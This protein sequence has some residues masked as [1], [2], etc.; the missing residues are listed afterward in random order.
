M[1][2]L[3]PPIP[4]HATHDELLVARLA[5][6]DTLD[7]Q[8]QATASA[9]VAG[10]PDCA[11]MASDIVAIS[12]AVAS[13]AV[14]P[15]RRDY[16]ISDEQAARLRG[17]AVERFFRRFTLTSGGGALK[18][19][20][21]GALSIGLVLV[22]VGS[23]IPRPVE[24]AAAPRVVLSEVAA[25]PSVKVNGIEENDTAG[26]EPPVADQQLEDTAGD[27][28]EMMMT[29]EAAP[30]GEPQGSPGPASAPNLAADAAPEGAAQAR[31]R[32]TVAPSP[33]TFAA[34]EPAGDGVAD[35]RADALADALT[36]EGRDASAAASVV[37]DGGL[38]VG[39]V[40]VA[41]GVALV[42]VGIVLGLL[43]VLA[44]RHPDPLR[45]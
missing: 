17:S 30:A 23:V 28:A 33:A 43:L 4:A 34:G 6:G 27:A 26:G 42:A 45:P 24:P 14:P 16:R 10:C 9:L 15:R 29:L 31:E 7:P 39:L 41:V 2:H 25:S 3:R 22:F 44:R 36:D 19:L 32:R 21:S 18:P 12:H 20:A 1:S 13:E 11:R 35:P 40:L 38:D 8:E 37:D 5:G